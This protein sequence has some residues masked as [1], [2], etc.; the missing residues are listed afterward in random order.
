VVSFTPRPPYVREETLYSLNMK[1]G[2]T[3]AVV[4][5]VWRG[6]KSLPPA[7]IR[8]P[9]CSARSLTAII[10]TL[11]RFQNKLSSSYSYSIPSQSNVDLRLLNGLLPTCLVFLP[12]FLTCNFALSNSCLHTQSVCIPSRYPH[13]INP[14]PLPWSIPLRIFQGHSLIFQTFRFFTVTSCR[15]VAHPPTWR[16]SV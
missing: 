10:T 4:C 16:V 5:T 6:L 12:L 14:Y 15:L 13:L 9:D 3:L 1:L 11:S 2:W 8:T 7:E